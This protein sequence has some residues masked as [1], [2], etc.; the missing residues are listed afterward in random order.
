MVTILVIICMT[1]FTL[2]IVTVHASPFNNPR[3]D[4]ATPEAKPLYGTHGPTC[5]DLKLSMLCYTIQEHSLRA[6]HIGYVSSSFATSKYLCPHCITDCAALCALANINQTC[7]TSKVN[8]GDH[9]WG[10]S[11]PTAVFTIHSADDLS[12]K[13]IT[14]NYVDVK[15]AAQNKL[16]DNMDEVSW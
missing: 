8:H 16:N 2:E 15:N 5:H 6:I 9:V 13:D 1:M 12:P 3:G 7:I 11:E 4:P 14:I 10:Q